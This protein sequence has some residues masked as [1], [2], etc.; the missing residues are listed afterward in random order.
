[1][2]LQKVRGTLNQLDLFYF[3]I[4]KYYLLSLGDVAM[5]GD[6]TTTEM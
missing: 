1:M 6:V 2:V 4:D 3:L 5:L